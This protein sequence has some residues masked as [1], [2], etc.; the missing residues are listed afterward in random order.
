MFGRARRLTATPTAGEVLLPARLR[1]EIEAEAREWAPRET[2][3]MLVGY[4]TARD[5]LMTVVITGTIDAGPGARRARWRFVP[6][7]RWQQRELEK[8]YK[9][10]GRI[11]TYLG[12][13]HSHPRGVPTPS[14][15]DRRTY[16]RVAA[17]ADT[18]TDLPVVLIAATGRHAGI[19]AFGIA[20]DQTSSALELRASG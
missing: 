2:G 4:R 19:A 11:T 18:G 7:G 14:A 5:G 17:E 1:A 16:A 10:S 3:G 9:R 15:V 20:A 13:W 8:F 6:D 12:D